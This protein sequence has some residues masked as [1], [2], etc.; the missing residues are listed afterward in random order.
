MNKIFLL[1]F[2]PFNLI[3]SLLLVPNFISTV[4]GQIFEF[5]E[6]DYIGLDNNGNNQNDEKDEKENGEKNLPTTNSGTMPV[7]ADSEDTD[8]EPCI[9]GPFESSPVVEAVVNDKPY[10]ST[11]H[12]VKKFDKDGNLVGSF[13]SPGAKDGQFLHAHGITID[14]QDNIFVSDAERCDIQKFD[15]DGNFVT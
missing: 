9:D 14:S 10:T 13:G 8:K 4:Y 15:K 7:S 1:A 3:I 11:F 12:F 6:D 2:I 5:N